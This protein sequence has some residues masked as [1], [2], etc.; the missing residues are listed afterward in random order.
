MKIG[1]KEDPPYVKVTFDYNVLA[2][3]MATLSSYFGHFKWANSYRL[4]M[5]LM[6]RYAFLKWFFNLENSRFRQVYKVSRGFTSLKSQFLYFKRKFSGDILLF[7]VG[8]YYEFYQNDSKDDIDN[9]LK[10]KRIQKSSI[11]KVSCGFPV[12]LEEVYINR[13]KRIGESITVIGE[14]DRYLTRVKERLPKYR[15]A[16]R[17]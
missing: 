9:M 5:D 14:E 10:L 2:K 12:R 13:L 11:R 7:Q 4:Q 6:K 17:Q 3:L 15:L 16:L 8:N 1:V